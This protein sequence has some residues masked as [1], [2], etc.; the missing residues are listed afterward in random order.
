MKYKRR[1]LPIEPYEVDA[2]ESWLSDCSA[3]GLFLEKLN[4]I[5]ATFAQKEPHRMVYRLIPKKDKDSY[6]PERQEA[7]L[8][9]EPGWKFIASLSR[10]FFI[11]AA[12][13]GTAEIYTDPIEESKQYTLFAGKEET[14]AKKFALSA[15]S[16]AVFVFYIWWELKKFFDKT[17]YELVQYTE[18]PFATLPLLL[19][20]TIFTTQRIRGFRRLQ[21][22][23]ATGNPRTH[24]AD[25]Q[26]FQKTRR[27]KLYYIYWVFYI[28]LAFLP[29]LPF[30][31]GY[32]EKAMTEV[33][34]PLPQI[35]LAD[36][37]ND[38]QFYSI[39]TYIQKDGRDREYWWER[40]ANLVSSRFTIGASVQLS[41]NQAGMVTGKTDAY[42]DPY[43]PVLWVHYYR[44]SPLVTAK[45]YID[46]YLSLLWHST[47]ENEV[48]TDTPFDYAVLSKQKDCSTLFLVF[49]DA[50][51]ELSYSYGDAD[52]T[53]YYHLYLQA[54]QEYHKT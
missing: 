23:L 41:Y 29:L 34:E 5:F 1:F 17:A 32:S 48:L 16:M 10:Y 25:W 39:H 28:A 51:L 4:T 37:E 43:Q 35:R 22:E 36:L 40:E 31:F 11:Y 12:E 2:L 3:E 26:D 50:L 44:F 21:K 33:T 45:E 52:L 54:L 14:P 42:G 7:A 15:L 24:E 18:F 38:P 46:S 30:T 19:F 9:E 20:G 47:W 6:I 53:K 27:H 8:Y 49:E 13:E